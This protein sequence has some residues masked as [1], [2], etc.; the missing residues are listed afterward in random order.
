[1]GPPGFD[2]L[3]G[4][5]LGQLA[6]LAADQETPADRRISVLQ[7]LAVMNG[8]VLQRLLDSQ[9]L[10]L[11]RVIAE[12][13]WMDREEQLDAVFLAVLARRPSE[14]ERADL[15]AELQ[16]MDQGAARWSAEGLADVCWSLLNSVEFW[17]NH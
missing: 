11:P 12:S 6:A 9:V 16:T 1:M 5:E 10:T 17:C 13:D 15:T 7:S 8:P 2:F 4:D 14:Q 3:A